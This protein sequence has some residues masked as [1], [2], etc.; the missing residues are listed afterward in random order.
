MAKSRDQNYLLHDQYK[1]ATNFNA[2][3]NLSRRFSVNKYGFSR[4]VFD[5]FQ[6]NAKSKVLELGCGP[7][8]LWYSNRGCIPASWQ[9]TLSDFSPGMLQEARQRLGAER[10]SFQVVDAQAIPFA[11][12][13]FETVI[14]NYMLYHMP[15]LPRALAEIRRVLKPGGHLYATTI[16]QKHL[17]ELDKLVLQAWPDIHWIGLGSPAVAFGLENGKSKLAQFFS[18]IALHIYE[19]SLRVT[20][21]GPLTDYVFSG[22]LGSQLSEEKRNAFRELIEQ[23]LATHGALYLTKASGLFEARKD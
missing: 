10:F 23:D 6:I 8:F 11:D 4:W 13:S 15:D 7:G 14:A 19:D 2:R 9:I 17:C 20:E 12:E 21:A 16:G 22:S 1:D 5:Q 18:Q 3:V